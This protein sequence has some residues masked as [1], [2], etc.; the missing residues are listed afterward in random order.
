[1]TDKQT[2]AERQANME[3]QWKWERELH[4]AAWELALR[5]AP[6]PPAENASRE[7]RLLWTAG[8]DETCNFIRR[9]MLNREP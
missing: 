1:V 5:F 9:A 3:A 2:K 7:E 6:T 4:E 8:L